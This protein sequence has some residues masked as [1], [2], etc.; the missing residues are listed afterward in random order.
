MKA[1]VDRDR[2]EGY[3]TCADILPSVFLLDEWGYAY[4]DENHVIA[5]AE[6]DVA[7]RAA[8]ECPM[9]AIVLGE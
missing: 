9:N 8:L 7:R 5:E 3:G 1:S 6:V 4:T 2:C